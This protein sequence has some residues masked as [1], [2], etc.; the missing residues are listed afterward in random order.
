MRW[1]WV[2]FVTLVLVLLAGLGVGYVAYVQGVPLG[3]SLLA[4]VVAGLVVLVWRAIRT[5]G[6]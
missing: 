2:D 6:R 4:G 3:E 5:R 1:L